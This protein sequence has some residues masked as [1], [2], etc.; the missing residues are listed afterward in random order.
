VLR[1][2]SVCRGSC[3]QDFVEGAFIRTQLVDTPDGGPLEQADRLLN[4]SFSEF[5]E[6]EPL[7]GQ[8]PQFSP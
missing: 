7:E 3:R 6:P 4:C 2:G 5:S 1:L 8:L